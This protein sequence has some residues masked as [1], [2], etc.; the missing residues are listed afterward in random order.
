MPMYECSKRDLD[1]RFKLSAAKIAEIVHRRIAGE[2][3]KSLAAAYAVDQ[4]TISRVI[5]RY[6]ESQGGKCD[7]E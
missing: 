6:L 3:Q 4:S 2:T 7:E 5:S 1:C